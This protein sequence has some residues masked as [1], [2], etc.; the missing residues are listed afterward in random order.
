MVNN[1]GLALLKYIIML[2]YSHFEIKMQHNFQE[3]NCF[4][5]RLA[6]FGIDKPLDTSTKVLMTIV[7][8]T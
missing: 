3:G 5:D 6:N 4:D 1:A 7:L 2:L 8:L